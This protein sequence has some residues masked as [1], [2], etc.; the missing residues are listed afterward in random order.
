MSDD[1]GHKASTAGINPLDGEIVLQNAHQ[2][3]VNWLRRLFFAAFLL[4]LGLSIGGS[5]G[6]FLMMLALVLFL[7][8]Y[9]SRR[10]S[11]YIVTNQRVKQ[12]SGL[13]GTSTNEAR[14]ETLNG[15]STQAGFIESLFGKGTV[16][17][18]DS[19]REQFT[20]DGVGN[21]EEVARTLREQ[22]QAANQPGQGR[23]QQPAG[24]QQAPR[25][26]QQAPAGGQQ[27]Q[28]GGQRQNQQQGRQ[29]Q[30]TTD[31]SSSSD[32]RSEQQEQQDESTTSTVA[33]RDRCL[34][35]GELVDA[36]VDFCPECGTEDPFTASQ[37][38][39]TG[40]TTSD[41]T[42]A[43]TAEGMQA[44][45]TAEPETADHPVTAVAESVLTNRRPRSGAADE[46]CRALADDDP[47]RQRVETALVDAVEAIERSA[48]VTDAV[49]Q[50]T[51][52]T[53]QTQVESAQRSVASKEGDLATAIE[54]VLDG[55][56]SLIGDL[57]ECESR[58]ERLSGATGEL[59]DT[60]E[61]EH[62]V[63]IRANNAAERASQATEA[64]ETAAA[65]AETSS[66]PLSSVV[67]DVERS[68]RPRT[69]QSRELL[70][71]LDEH[72]DGELTEVLRSTVESLDEHDELQAAVAEISQRDVRRRLTSLDDEL[73]REEGAVYRHLA[74]RIREMETMVERDDIDGVQLYAI[75]QECTFYDRT[76]LPRLS[77]EDTGGKSVDVRGLLD[78][79]ESRRSRIEDEYV[80]VRADHNHTIP[81]HFLSLAGN[82]CAEAKSVSDDRPERAAGI[83]SASDELLE[84]VEQLYERNEYSVMLRRLRG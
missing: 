81:N 72:D 20:I 30:N 36:D 74:D 18:T 8:V 55:T 66:A 50:I 24:G 71:A 75:Y 27:T 7:S 12:T 5:P 39:D 78:D 76:L 68:A 69:E 77:R 79:V 53:D 22:Q 45:R 40:T 42:N 47:D 38:E 17:V 83:L 48:A 84:H 65:T 46:L 44:T 33:K 52:P 3:W 6:G 51:D 21:Y 63:R 9:F 28:T 16:S 59:C 10:A 31:N 29:A 14:L 26:G 70:D 80:T 67:D 60:V 61:R 2:S 25:G 58:H 54:P 57:A 23:Y 82:L 11:R 43:T 35:C 64:V 4:V 13:L 62:D 34:D 37:S 1:Q 56:S 73:Q 32:S 41:D 15:I 19:A 49:D